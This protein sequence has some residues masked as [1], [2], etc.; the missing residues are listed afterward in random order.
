VLKE[1]LEELGGITFIR[2]KIVIVSMFLL[3]LT[4]FSSISLVTAEKDLQITGPSEGNEGSFVEF[5]ITLDG[6]PIQARVSF[7]SVET[8]KYSHPTTGK[9]NFT[10]PSIDQESKEFF[11]TVTY[12][13]LQTTSTILV[14]NSASVL[15]LNIPQDTIDELQQFN[16]SVTSNNNPIVDAYVWF[17]SAYY[18]TNASGMVLLTA[19]DLLV[20]TSYKISVNKT[21]YT[22]NATTMT[23]QENNV[24]QKLMELIA[25]SIVE[26]D[27]HDIEIHILGKLG[28]LSEVSIELYYEQTK[29]QEYTT[30]ELG[31][32]YIS[33][34]VIHNDNY[35]TLVFEKEEYD[36]Y[37]SDTEVVISLLTRDC[38]NDLAIAIT[39]TEVYEGESVLITVTND[40]GVGVSDVTIW[41]GE[42]ELEGT[43]DSEGIFSFISPSVFLDKAFYIYALKQGYNYG[44][45]TV[46]IRDQISSRTILI[47]VERT[48]EEGE[49]FS[50]ILTNEQHDPLQGVSVYFNAQKQITDEYGSVSFLAPEVVDNT[51][52]SLEAQR[53]G[54]LPASVTIEIVDSD[55][56]NGA[57][58]KQLSIFTVKKI[59]EKE[60]FSIL[61][62]DQY[63]NSVSNVQIK[64]L[65]TYS[66]TDYSGSITVKAPEV[67]WD[68]TFT[69]VATKA[70]Y[71]STSKSIGVINTEGFPYWY[72]FIAIIIIVIG[73]LAYFKYSLYF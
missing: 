18:L 7:E 40:V 59:S 39:P 16:V 71:E 63:G 49:L 56:G 5:T 66:Y 2:G 13:D 72:L 58:T 25:P 50:L 55:G 20:T 23:V 69:I 26:P 68:E 64:F 15:A 24:G 62:K 48:I 30:D 61:V 4:C 51:V 19:P 22:S 53:Y 1:S 29:I 37:D 14:K 33:S 57:S 73:L 70:N 44:E 46:T 38:E 21:G 67:S 12:L 34:P 6:V 52:Y 9:V 41:R 28:D 43:T 10:L 47:E 42:V 54:Y 8:S 17:N 35:F 31:R 45:G 11:V 60:S 3:V 36:T 32:A 27:T 65:G